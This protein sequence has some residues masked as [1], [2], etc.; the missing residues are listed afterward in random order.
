[1]AMKQE[2]NAP[3]ILTIGIVGALLFLVASFGVEAWYRAEEQAAIS[4]KFEH[5]VN[6]PLRDQYLAQRDKISSYRWIDREAQIIAIPIDQA[7]K[8]VV[9]SQGA[10]PTT[11]PQAQPAGAAER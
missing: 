7:M 11:R 9:E 10:L 8:L 1:M 5:A 4:G 2:V 6:I 3:L